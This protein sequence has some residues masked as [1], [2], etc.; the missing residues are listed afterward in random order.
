M[1]SEAIV[2]VDLGGTKVRVGKVRGSEVERRH[3]RR[4]RAQE[5]EASVLG[6]IFAA[7]DE[8]FDGDVAGIGCAVPSVV[9]VERGI[10]YAVENIPSWRQVHLKDELERRFGVPA[11]VNNDAKAFVLGELWFGKARGYRHVVGL[12]LGTGLGGGVVIDG[13]LYS[14]SNCGAGEACRLCG[15]SSSRWP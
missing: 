10:V 7:V 9:D 3:G 2:G 4:I 6:Q 14:G 13:R 8:V 15:R 1:A 12:T 11:L 5:D